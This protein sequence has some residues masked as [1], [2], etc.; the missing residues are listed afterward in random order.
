MKRI[1]GLDLGV[2]SIGWALISENENKNEI[3]GMGSRI[4]PLSN[5]DKDEFSKGNQISK[6]QKRTQKRTQRKGYDRYQQRRKA[7]TQFLLEHDM[8]DETLFKLKPLELWG[9]R[10]KSVNEK[11]SLKEFGRILYHLNQKRGY[12]SSRSDANLD[13][14]DTE[15]VAEVK[16]RHQEIK[17]NGITIGQKFYS[18]LLKDQ[19]YRIKQQVFPREAYIEEFDAI[20]R[21]QQKH[22]PDTISDE[23]I[24]ILREE[25]IYYQRRLKSQKGLV[26]VCEFEGFWVKSKEGKDIYAGPK[27]SPRSSP[28][29]QVCKIWE[30]INSIHL[31][32]KRGETYN[33]PIEKKWDIFHYL[34]NNEK[35]TQAE[36]FKILGLNKNDGWYGNQQIAKGLQGN[37]TKAELIKHI[38]VGSPWLAFNL[39]MEKIFLIDRGTGEILDSAEKKIVKPNIENL[40]LYRLWHTIYSIS[41]VEVC[42]NVLIQ[43]FDL[44]A[45]TAYQLSNIDFTKTAFG[46]KSVKAMR[47]ILPYLMEGHVYSRA[48]LFAGYNHSDS[49]TKDENLKRKLLDKIPLLAKNS[50]RQPVVEKILNQLINLVNAVIVQYGKPDEIRIELARELKQS[51]DERNETFSSLNKRERENETIR[52]RLIEYGIRATRNNVIKW[53]LFHEINGDESKLNAT[54]MYCGQPFGIKDA[55]SG[56]NVDVEHIIPKSLLFDDSQSNKTLSHRICNEA[57]GKLTAFDFMKAKGAVA[58]NDYI[59][60]VDSLY[61]NKI[62]GKSK[63]D[64]LLTP[65]EKIP[66]DFIER[67]MRET[68]YIARKSKEILE[69]VC[70]HV[71]ATSGTV[72]AHLRKLWGWEDVLMNLQLPKYREMGLTEWVEWETNN[73]KKF[74]NEVV[75][76][77]SKRDDHRHHAI[78]ALTI[79]CT[80]QGFIQRMNTLSAEHTK[81]EMFEEVNN[82]NAEFKEKLG[83]LDRYLIL[84][85]PFSTKKVQE[86]AAEIL[87][88]FKPGKR[89]A[90]IAK[91]KVKKG[92][93]KIVVQSGIVVPRGA[94]SE[95]F[96]YGRIKTIEKEK[97]VKY[98]FENPHLIFKPYIKTL[99]EERI[100]SHEGDVKKAIASLNKEPIYLDKEKEKVLE[101]GTCFKEDFVKKYPIEDIKLKDVE[102][103]IDQGL[104]SKIKERL[105]LFNDNVKEAYKEPLFFNTDKQFPVKTVRMMTGLSAVE[106]IRWDENGKEIGFVKPGNNHHIAF[107]IDE[108]G[109]KQEHIC[110]FWHAVERKKFGFPEIIRNPNEI[111]SKILENKN[112]YTESFLSKLPNDKW[113]YDLSMQQNEMF[114]LGLSKDEFSKIINEENKK[115]LSNHLFL[116]WSISQG[117]YWFRHHLET[118]NSELKSLSGAKQAKRYVRCNSIGAF[119][120]LNPYKIRINNLGEIVS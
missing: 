3:I 75:K 99:V 67:Q 21:Q 98:L 6:N 117:D 22:Y 120:K 11:V 100:A 53:R 15:Y 111:W 86:K 65:V 93:K 102:Y 95:D 35:L 10:A 105:I 104:K 26:N 108:N 49:R 30:T 42:R 89:V 109:K 115:S 18:E 82:Q 25:I 29:F 59:E 5:D 57:K 45:K 70:Y 24:K 119:E 113:V 62:I 52:K 51:R 97:S 16:N 34:D 103:I 27:V 90:T 14:K 74:K 76:D 1:L 118:K 112:E 31:K 64:K 8:F 47:K 110:S 46:N 37:L 77:W 9:L 32:N 106:P 91:R 48:C 28:L 116:I 2:A 72:T 94:L 55:I 101:Y 73:G 63:R 88:S 4:I 85:K 79:A 78:D 36:L 50:L 58:L 44:D 41:D 81:N 84:Q 19:Y 83:I 69:Q 68:Q 80:K 71:F 12:K 87:I 61:K 17:E 33:I 38:G 40:P 66:K 92:R 23:S 54:C 56:N 107:Y 20:C 39:E 96:V 7:L 114:V 43:K 60:R 13:K